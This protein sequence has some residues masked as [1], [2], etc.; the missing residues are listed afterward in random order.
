MGGLADRTMHVSGASASY[1]LSISRRVCV[2]GNLRYDSPLHSR[3]VVA[4]SVICAWPRIAGQARKSYLDPVPRCAFT[5]QLGLACKLH[6]SRL[7]ERHTHT[8]LHLIM[9]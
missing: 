7:Y 6:R 5:S 9:E 4:Q 1:N 2:A 3:E 8:S